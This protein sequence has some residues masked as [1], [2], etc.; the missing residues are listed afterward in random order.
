MEAS[1]LRNSKS[2]DLKIA[3]SKP[4]KRQSLSQAG[5]NTKR[6]DIQILGHPPP[7]GT[8]RG[9]G[10]PGRKRTTQPKYLEKQ[11]LT[12]RLFLPV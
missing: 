2:R 6:H 9:G 7:A 5:K 1:K 4:Q 8:R 11:A 10:T 3:I 12:L